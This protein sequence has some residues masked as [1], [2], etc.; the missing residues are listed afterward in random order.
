MTYPDDPMDVGSSTRW[1]DKM[2]CQ[3]ITFTT[4]RG[5]LYGQVVEEMFRDTKTSAPRTGTV[6]RACSCQSGAVLFIFA[7]GEVTTATIALNSSS[8]TRGNGSGIDGPSFLH[9]SRSGGGGDSGSRSSR[10]GSS[11]RNG[12]VLF[13]TTAIPYR[14]GYLLAGLPV[15]NDLVCH[16]LFISLVR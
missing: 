16:V 11:G 8:G 10:Y 9:C 14:V 4:V 7:V 13:L 15:R 6:G 5:F 3:L 12:P 2:P 1:N